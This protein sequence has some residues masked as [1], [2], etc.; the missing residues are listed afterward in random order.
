MGV[1]AHVV[2]QVAEDVG[3]AS[4]AEAHVGRVSESRLEEPFRRARVLG[5]VGCRGHGTHVPLK[6][7][8][9]CA[10][11]GV[12]AYVCAAGLYSA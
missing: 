3:L 2:E 1:V 8:R 4:E 6:V 5:Q 10:G 7:R 11:C 9:G 12:R